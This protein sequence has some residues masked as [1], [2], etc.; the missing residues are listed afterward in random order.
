MDKCPKVPVDGTFG[1]AL[2]S[3]AGSVSANETAPMTISCDA[4]WRQ[5]RCVDFTWLA[6][7]SIFF[8]KAFSR[9]IEIFFKKALIPT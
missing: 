6:A 2:R 5:F 9:T 8:V 4:N 1:E 3:E 7:E